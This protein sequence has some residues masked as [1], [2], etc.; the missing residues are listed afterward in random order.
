MKTAT[1]ASI[2][3]LQRLHNLSLAYASLWLLVPGTALAVVFLH[4]VGGSGA[5]VLLAAMCAA[6]VGMLVFGLVLTRAIHNTPVGSG[7]SAS[8]RHRI[9]RRFGVV[10]AAEFLGIGIV[11][12]AGVRTQHQAFIW[13]LSLIIVGLHF[14]PLARLF[15]VPR[16]NVTGV[17]LCAIPLS[18]ILLLPRTARIGYAQSRFVM[19]PLGCALVLLWTAAAGLREAGRFVSG[20][21]KGTGHPVPFESL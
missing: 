4:R 21:K 9:R 8:E 3:G 13:P 15:R 12:F 20:T 18:A 17:L 5:N 14:L 6:A 7:P 11:I 1:E 16:Y 2:V 19:P 10:V